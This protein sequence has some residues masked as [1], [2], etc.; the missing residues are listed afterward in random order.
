PSTWCRRRRAAALA[1]PSLARSASRVALRAVSAR[2]RSISLS[3]PSRLH[4]AGAEGPGAQQAGPP[5]TEPMVRRPRTQPN[6]TGTWLRRPGG[7]VDKEAPPPEARAAARAATEAPALQPWAPLS[8]LPLPRPT[9]SV[10]EAASAPGREE[11]AGMQ[12]RLA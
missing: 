1:A 5:A 7:A 12:M 10:V 3:S 2:R 6:V 8:T 11:L 9:R 4:A